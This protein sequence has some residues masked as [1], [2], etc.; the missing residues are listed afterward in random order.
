MIE[1]LLANAYVKGASDLLQGKIEGMPKVVVIPDNATNGD[2]IEATG[3]FEVV[4][5]LSN[6]M[7]VC[8]SVKGLVS[9]TFISFSRAWW[10]A[11]YKGVE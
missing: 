7:L 2:V 8:V 3:L 6:D 4:G 1:G 5:N 9:H 10:D 11:P